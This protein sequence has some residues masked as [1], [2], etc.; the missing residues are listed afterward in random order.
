MLIIIMSSSFYT[1]KAV[2]DFHAFN[3][4][5]RTL[6]KL[7]VD[8]IRS[9]NALNEYINGKEEKR[10]LKYDVEHPLDIYFLFKHWKVSLRNSDIFSFVGLMKIRFLA[11]I[12][13]LIS[14]I[15]KGTNP[16]EKHGENERPFTSCIL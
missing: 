2:S 4:D 14:K 13:K 7:E 9:E 1:C 8:V 5:L 10:L 16:R 11:I 3:E 15:Y 12:S 6:I